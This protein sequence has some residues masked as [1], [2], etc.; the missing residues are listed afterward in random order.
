[1]SERWRQFRNW[2]YEVS[3]LGDIRRMSTGRMMKQTTSRGYNRVCLCFAGKARTLLVHRVVAEVWI[4]PDLNMHVN[5]IDGVKTNNAVSNLEWVT[6]KENIAHSVS[7]GLHPTGARNGVNTKPHTRAFGDKNGMRLHPDS[8]MKGSR[9]PQSKLKESDIG[10]IISRRKDGESLKAIAVDYG[11][12]FSLISKI[13][14]G[15]FW[16]HAAA[17]RALGGGEG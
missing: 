14:R 1:M 5:H 11:V 7:S 6:P 4:R 3:N 12:S 13:C 8:T 15:R 17:I 10:A 16:K 2:D 9:N